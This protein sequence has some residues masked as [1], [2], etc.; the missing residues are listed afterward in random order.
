M[1][2]PWSNITNVEKDSITTPIIQTGQIKEQSKIPII[3]ICI[4]YRNWEPEFIEK[5]YVPLRSMPVDFAIKKFCLSKVPSIPTARNAAIKQ[6]LDANADYVFFLDTDHSF[7]DPTNKDGFADPN[8]ALRV[9]YGAMSK[10]PNSKQDK[11]VSGLYRAKQEIGLNYAMWMSV[12]KGYSPIQEWTG[13]WISVD[14]VGL[15]CCLIDINVFKNVPRP[16]FHWDEI[17]EIS[18]DFYFLKKAKEYGYGTKV[19]TDVKLSHMG[20]LKVR[21]DGSVTLPKM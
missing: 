17:D 19:F 1:N 9:L 13:N 15:G 5:V 20:K 11:I 6:A 14:V 7:E 21:C 18:E 12:E 8:A 4:P 2:T 16:W 3:A 10:D